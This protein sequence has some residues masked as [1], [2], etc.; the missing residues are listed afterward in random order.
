MRRNC[1]FRSEDAASQ[2]HPKRRCGAKAATASED[3]LAPPPAAHDEPSR[4]AGERGPAEARSDPMAAPPRAAASQGLG[5]PGGAASPGV[6]PQWGA[7]ASK[8][9]HGEPGGYPPRK[10]PRAIAKRTESPRAKSDAGWLRG[11]TTRRRIH[12]RSDGGP[13]RRQ[14]LRRG[15]RAPLCMLTPNP[16]LCVKTRITGH[17][18]GAQFLLKPAT[19]CLH[20]GRCYLPGRLLLVDPRG[21]S[22]VVVTAI[23]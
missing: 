18:V 16:P 14:A 20:S 4:A 6:G 15:T 11:Q 3:G 1:R 19:D 10:I 9:R 7:A 12:R 2:P 21:L 22:A 23:R 5:P 17:R 8:G 13:E